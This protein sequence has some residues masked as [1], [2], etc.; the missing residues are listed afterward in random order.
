[1]GINTFQTLGGESSMKKR[2]FVVLSAMVV[3]SML[4]AGCGPKPVEEGEWGVMTF[5]P[6]T[7]IKIGVSSALA[8]GYAVYGQDMLNGVNLAISDFG[9]LNGWSLVAEGGC[10]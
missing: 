2:L 5:A 8:G 1:M 9:T 3:F 10:C 6:G 7:E 4:L